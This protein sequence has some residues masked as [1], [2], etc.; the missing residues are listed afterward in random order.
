MMRSTFVLAA[1][2]AASVVGVAAFVAA[3]LGAFD[4]VLD[5]PVTEN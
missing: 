3:V 4:A 2:V 5:R 1:G